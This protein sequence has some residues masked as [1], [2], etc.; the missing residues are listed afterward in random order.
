MAVIRFALIECLYSAKCKSCCVGE[1][2]YRLPISHTEKKK[3]EEEDD[4]EEEEKEDKEEEEAEKEDKGEEK[5]LGR[6][7]LSNIS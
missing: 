7:L 6:L 2:R 1:A 4:E 3:E 5:A